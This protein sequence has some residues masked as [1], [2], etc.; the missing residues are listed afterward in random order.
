[1]PKKH[2]PSY[3]QTKPSYVH[4]SLQG[5]RPSSSTPAE[6]QTVNQRIQQLRREQ[7]P[8]ATP[9]QRDEITSLVSRT[10]PPELRRILHIPE[11]NAPK[12]KAGLRPRRVLGAARPPP[13]PAAPSSWLQTSRHAPAYMRKRKQSSV[14]HGAPRFSTLAT[15][16]DE[17]YKRLPPPRS[18]VHQCLRSFAMHWE[19]LCEYEQHY[20]PALP[21]SLKE[22]LLS[23]LTLFG[24]NVCLDFKSFK[25]LFQNDE[26][27]GTSG[28]DETRFLDLAGLLNEQLTVSDVGQCLRRPNA[29][30]TALE[31]GALSISPEKAKKPKEPAVLQVVDSWEEEAEETP[32]AQPV[33]VASLQVPHFT[34]LSRLSLAHPGQWASWPELLRISPH[35]GKLTHLSLA[36]WPRPSMTPNALSTSMVSNHTSVSLGGS[37]F[38]SDLDDDWHEAANILRRFSTN[39]YSLQWLDLEGCNWLRAL[40]WRSV[41]LPGPP[42]PGSQDVEPWQIHSVSP[43]PDWND[44]WRRITYLNVFQGWIPSDNQSL[45]NMPAGIVPVQLMRWLRE[46]KAKDDVRWRLNANETGHAVAEWVQREKVAKGVGLDIHEIRKSGKGL[47]CSIDHGW[48]S[49]AGDNV[50][51]VADRSA[52]G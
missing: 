35:L 31:M 50:H 18:L 6:P 16:T 8:R 45:Q 51:Q 40:T 46:N 48:G 52:A 28:W 29:S 22:A 7:A 39:T 14:E 25:I 1:M 24:G 10:V 42:V 34:N 26:G 20:L 9:E 12:P 41:S 33:P 13:G 27:T 38:Y 44:A 15:V 36:F 30:Q 19:E 17:E 3:A 4:P 47:W 43:S 49:A 2:T 21:I 32:T 23:Y 37:H 5:S 11:V